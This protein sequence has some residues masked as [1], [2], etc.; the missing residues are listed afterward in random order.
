METLLMPQQ[1]NPVKHVLI[2][3]V[4]VAALISCVS[5]RTTAVRNPEFTDSKKFTKVVVYGNFS[6]LA[7]RKRVEDSLVGALQRARISAIPSTSIF[8][9]VPEKEV[10][11]AKF[12]EAGADAILVIQVTGAN[13]TAHQISGGSSSTNASASCYGSTCQ[14]SSTTTYD[15]P[16]YVN[17][18]HMALRAKLVDVATDKLVWQDEG[19]SHGGGWTNFEMLEDSFSAKVTEDLVAS[20]L[21]GTAGVARQE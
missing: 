9:Q 8:I 11:L 15:G 5:T 16:T 2:L 14:G 13:V 18:P 19:E 6:N 17:K 3:I 1:A 12:T 7:T 4:L 10:G 20:G 21:F